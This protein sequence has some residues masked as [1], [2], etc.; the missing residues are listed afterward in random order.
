MSWAY[1]YTY[2]DCNKDTMTAAERDLLK[3]AHDQLDAGSKASSTASSKAERERDVLKFV[4]DQLDAG[5]QF[6]SALSLHTTNHIVSH[7]EM[8]A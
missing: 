5:M 3:F 1:G 7:M 6:T 4:H 8:T 2:T